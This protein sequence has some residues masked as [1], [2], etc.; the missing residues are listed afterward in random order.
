ALGTPV[1]VTRDTTERTEGLEAGTL[2]LVG[3]E[4]AAIAR[5]AHELLTDP[6]A[7]DAMAFAANPYGDGK[8]APRV[9]AALENLAGRA[10][11][12]ARYGSGFNRIKVLRAGGYPGTSPVTAEDA[13]PLEESR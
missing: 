6:R 12:P 4:S 2:A 7:H 13:A 9:V 5:A 3:T 1:L 8:A 11:D 10:P